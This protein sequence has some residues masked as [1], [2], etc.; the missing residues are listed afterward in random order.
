MLKLPMWQCGHVSWLIVSLQLR[1][2]P[3]RRL[4]LVAR[5]TE[6][7]SISWL[8]YR[9]GCGIVS[10]H[11]GSG[12][13]PRVSM[14]KSARVA[15]DLETNCHL[16][17]LIG[18][19]HLVRTQNFRDFGPPPSPLYAFRATYQ[20]CCTQKLVISLTP[21]PPQRVRTK[22]KPPSVYFRCV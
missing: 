17:F 12:R 2:R 5:M 15:L 1:L 18:G 7:S 16:H 6:V 22:W 21:P 10:R 20:Y 4:Q 3:C 9:S 19:F 14:P 13:C 8:I 11:C